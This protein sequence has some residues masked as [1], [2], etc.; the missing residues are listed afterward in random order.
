[1][2]RKN[3]LHPVQGQIV[4]EAN[5]KPTQQLIQRVVYTLTALQ[6][7]L[8]VMQMELC[9]SVEWKYCSENLV[10]PK[11]YVWIDSLIEFSGK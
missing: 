3:A 1:M 4:D 11:V 2:F 9:Y 10:Q 5:K 8:R 7:E 6:G